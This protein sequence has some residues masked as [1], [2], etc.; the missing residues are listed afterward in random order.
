MLDPSTF[1]FPPPPPP[2]P[3]K[4]TFVLVFSI[5]LF[6]V[7]PPPRITDD[8]TTMLAPLPFSSLPVRVNPRDWTLLKSAVSCSTVVPSSSTLWA[9]VSRY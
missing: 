6:G 5:V 4:I 7:W 3:P 2:P 1:D 9:N 8:F